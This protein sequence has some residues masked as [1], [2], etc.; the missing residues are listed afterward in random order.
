ML[1]KCSIFL[2]VVFVAAGLGYGEQQKTRDY[3][4]TGGWY[5]RSASQL[6]AL[7]DGFFEKAK[8]KPAPGKIVGI[9]APH[10][11]FSY[12]GPSAAE[13]YKLLENPKTAA[14]IQRV[15]LLGVSHSS[16]FHGA[17]VSTFEYNATPLGKIPV[18]TAITRK[19]AKE[20]LFQVHNHA[21]QREHSIENHLP[22]L[23]RA[24][25]NRPFKIVPILMGYLDKKDFAKIAAVIRKYIDHKTLVVA[26]TDFTHYGANF[27]YTPF[28]KNLKENLTNLDM[29]MIK[30]ITRLAFD[31][32]YAYKK[33]TGITMCGFNP[34]GV[35]ISIFADG[36]HGAVLMDY[37][38]S[39]DRNGDY[40]HSVSYA[41]IVVHEGGKKKMEPS[42]S[43]DKK[44]QKILL[45]IARDT[46][47]QYLD[48]GVHPQELEKKYKLTPNLE[49][50]TGVFVT[51]KRRGQLRGCIGTIM[52]VA[53]LYLGVRDNA[54]KAAVNDYRFNRVEKKE[55]KKLDIEISVMTPL[56]PLDDYR[57]IRL[58]VDGVIIR[59]GYNRAVYLPQVA[60]ET[61]WSLDRLL[62]QLCRKAGLPPHSYIESE[63]MEFHIFQAQVFSERH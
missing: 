41:S 23:Q 8:P 61:G 13:A 4:T 52:G 38:K 36:K 5:P 12:S 30:P 7:L 40:S 29:G 32:Y 46:L 33:E 26:S 60:T 35:L 57:K 24:L 42:L 9:I 59:K 3:L 48:N 54:I 62:R 16:R 17:A 1:R 18:D 58:G 43:L 63:D 25:R 49:E 45:K 14:S 22:F 11:G 15:I 51:L 6:N 19:L 20:K 50:V 28:R 10:A 53:P 55:L 21:M 37:R 47:E 2:I 31:P 27:R 34:V 56:R 39:G 44:E